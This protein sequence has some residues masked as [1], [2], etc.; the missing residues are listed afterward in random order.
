[1]ETKDTNKHKV[2]R[3]QIREKVL[4][5][6][7]AYE[8]AKDPIEKIKTD[9]LSE[10]TET[11]DQ[12][13]ANKLIH[14]SIDNHDR[15]EE[16]TKTAVEHWDLERIALLDLI[17]IRMCLSEFFC[18]EEIP[19]KVSINEAIEL[20]KDYSTKN[21][22]KFVNGVLDAILIKLSK[23][24]EIKKTGKGLIASSSGK[25]KTDKKK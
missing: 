12:H 13:F 25:T 8:I 23:E 3:R 6:L 19:S 7:Y 1:M 2:T 20:A 4:H 10:L 9:L 5:V 15:F 18:F 11:E 24:G 17:I 16:L 14:S 22:G 21:S